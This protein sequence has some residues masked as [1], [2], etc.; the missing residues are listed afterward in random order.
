VWRIGLLPASNPLTSLAALFAPIPV[1]PARPLRPPVPPRTPSAKPPFS[2]DP[3][4]V[5]VER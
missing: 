1:D 3:A 4:A 2:T 5:E